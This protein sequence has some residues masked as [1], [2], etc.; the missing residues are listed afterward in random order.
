MILASFTAYIVD[1]SLNNIQSSPYPV[2]LNFDN[3]IAPEPTISIETFPPQNLQAGTFFNIDITYNYGIPLYGN[4]IIQV[5]FGTNFVAANINLVTPANN[6]NRLGCQ[7]S[8]TSNYLFSNVDPSIIPPLPRVEKCDLTSVNP[9][10]IQL[11]E[12]S[13]G[14]TEIMIS[15]TNLIYPTGSTSETISINVIRGSVILVQNV[16]TTLAA[17]NSIL[18]NFFPFKTLFEL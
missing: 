5:Y 9:I 4:E 3:F 15:L 12:P 11:I 18:S 17:L 1:N 13:F 10:Q 6:N 8:F 14:R 7:I 16:S 2:D